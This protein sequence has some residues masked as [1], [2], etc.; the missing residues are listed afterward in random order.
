MILEHNLILVKYPIM[1]LQKEFYASFIAQRLTLKVINMDTLYLVFKDRFQSSKP[2]LVARPTHLVANFPKI[3]LEV[4]LA[5]AL[6]TTI[7]R[8]KQKGILP[9]SPS[10][11]KHYFFISESYFQG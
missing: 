2:D 6:Q 10:L 4:V 5:F 9:N 3:S 8:P 7:S 11:V 1:T